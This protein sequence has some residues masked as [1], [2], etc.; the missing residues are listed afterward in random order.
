MIGSHQAA[1]GCQVPLKAAVEPSLGEKPRRARKRPR[2]RPTFREEASLRAEGYSLVAGLDEVGRG[3]LAGPVVA[4]LAILPERLRGRWVRLVRDSK[5]MTAAER[6]Y[7]LPRLRDTA[8]ALEIG[9]STSREVDE[10]GIVAATRLAMQRAL[11]SVALLPQFLLL[12]AISLPRVPIPQRSIVKGDVLCISISAA[13]IVAK[14][15][16]DD[17]MEREDKTYPGYGFAQHKGYGT[18]GHIRSIDRLGP[19]PIHRRSFAPVR[20]MFD[21]L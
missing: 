11:D 8:L 17:M 5:Q 18:P 9:V 12:D 13:S 7:V 3:P 4:G 2:P 10:L 16:R 15:A 6:E 1:D 19:C 20:E 21:A 14:V